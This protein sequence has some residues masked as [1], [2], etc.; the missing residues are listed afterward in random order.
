MTASAA[1]AAPAA[2]C[3]GGFDPSGGA[4]LL[5][6]VMTL[7]AL[8]VHPMAVSTGDTLQNGL[9]CE[10]ILPPRDPMPALAAL[11][12][13]LAGTWGVKLGLCALEPLALGAIAD[14]LAERRPVAAI[15]DP[16]QAPTSG[17]GLHGPAGLRALAGALLGRGDWV[18]SPNRPE[19]AALSGLPA[20]AEP[21][22]LARPL[23]AAGASAVWIKGGHGEGA[24]L[25]DVWVTRRGAEGLGR[26]PR[27]PGDRRGTGCTLASAW[28]AFRLQGE[29][30]EAAARAAAAWLRSRW[31]EAIRP[32][33]AGRPCFAPAGGRP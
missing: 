11:A 5:R 17:V 13:H 33:G 25:E 9:G 22:D 27:L 2:L 26:S 30:P 15:W 3:L 23:L 21:G 8:G 14:F 18:V 24:E 28:L 1:P 10:A 29:A 20:T 31:P 19:A 16:V 4:G 32:G 6:D 12:P 7:A